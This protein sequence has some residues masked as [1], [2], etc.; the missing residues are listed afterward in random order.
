MLVVMEEPKRRKCV[1]SH[2]CAGSST[3]LP[4]QK[5]GRVTIC[6]HNVNL[7]MLLYSNSNT[8]TCARRACEEASVL[9]DSHSLADLFSRVE[10]N[11]DLNTVADSKVTLATDLARQR[12]LIPPPRD[13][14]DQKPRYRKNPFLTHSRRR[15]SSLLSA[16][17]PRRTRRTYVPG[18]GS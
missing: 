7:P 9:A 11:T 3:L 5:E 15:R 14:S 10:I 8:R 17:S 16:R 12:L 13:W 1:I 2:A 18:L 6:G 4:G